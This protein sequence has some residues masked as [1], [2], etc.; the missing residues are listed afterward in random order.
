MSGSKKHPLLVTGGIIGIGTCL[1][2]YP[3]VSNFIYEKS[4]EDMILEMDETE[5]DDSE[6]EREKEAADAYNRYLLEENIILTD[7][8]DPEAFAKD[9][10][11]GYE[12]ILNTYGN[13][14][15]GYL[16][17]PAINLSLG[18]YHGTS[19]DVLKNG[20]GHLENTSLPV[21][22]KNTHAVLSAHTG[23]SDKKLFTDL[24]LLE[25]GDMFYIHVLDEVLAY[26][27]DQ[28]AVVEPEDTSLLYVVSDE[29]LV[30]LVTCT[31]YGVNSHRLLVRGTRVP[32]VEEEKEQTEN[33][34]SF[35]ASSWMKQYAIAVGAGTV[36]VAVILAAG[37]FF[38]RKGKKKHDQS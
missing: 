14:L 2:V 19:A 16:E 38:D 13:G 29:D 23:L 15:M 1:A 32:Y 36:L 4:Q 18:I 8:F 33:K 30:T 22:G 6:I 5:I 25:E 26:K 27:V 21:G 37:I 20:V 10:E 9:L 35:M 17:V 34:A 7:P 11:M 24:V 3:F 28:I 12:D 31:P